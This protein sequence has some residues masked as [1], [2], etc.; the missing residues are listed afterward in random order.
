MFVMREWFRRLFV[1][2]IFEDEEKTRTAQI[3]NTFGWIAFAVVFIITLSR[4]VTGEWL[5]PSSRVFFPAILL[6]LFAIQV[7]IRY[8]FVRAAGYSLVIFMWGALTYQASQSDGVRDVA[9]L[10]YPVIILLAALL[11]GWREGLATGVF[12]LAVLWFFAWQESTGTRQYTIDP[13]LSYARDL[14]AVFIITSVLVYILI[15]R[16]NRSLT[17]AQLELRERLRVENK[18]QLQANYL[19]ALHETAFGLLNRLELNPLLESILDRAS[20]LL[21][22][23]HVGINLVLPDDSALRQELGRGAFAP[24]NGDLTHKGE[25][26]TGKVW[27][28]G[29][30]I[31]TQNYNEYEFGTATAREKGFQAVLGVPLKSGQKVV[32]ALIVGHTDP[33]SQFTPEQVVL[34][35]RLAALAS[36]AFD[37]AR[38][39]EDAHTE[40]MERKLVERDLRA[41]EERFRKVFNNKNVAVS[42]V[43][44]EEGIF[45]E[46]ND[47]FWRLSG[48]SPEKALGHS[49]VELHMWE[50][51]GQREKFVQELLKTGSLQDVEVL[52][53]DGENGS[54]VS[55]AYYELI[56]I[57]EQQCIL[58][59]FYDVSG[60]R[61][62]ERALKESE[63]RFRKV[64]YASPIAICITTLEEGRLLDA[65]KAYWDLTGYDPV[66]SINLTVAEL[67]MWDA[68]DLRNAFVEEIKEKR[69]VL[70]P[71]YEFFE[72]GSDKKHH[73]IA[74]YELID[75]NGQ[76]CILSMFYDITEQRSAEDALKSAEARTRAILNAIPDMIFEVSRSGVILDFMA[77]AGYSPVMEPSKFLG[78]NIQELFPAVIAEQ[79]FFA[80]ERS[81]ASGQ[82]HAF[83]YGL[84][85]GEDVQFF[86]A[87][88]SAV[89]VESAIMM[90]RDISQRR[91][92]ETE[93]EK[94][95][96]EL[97]EK[98]SE[99]ERFTYTVS[100]D[101]KSPLITIKGFLGFL[102]QD[103]SS[104]NMTRLRGDLQR[105]GDA[106]DKMQALLNELLELSRIG[107]LVNPPQLVPFNRVIEEA[108]GLVQGR[109]HAK[110]IEV[111]VQKNLPAVYGD[112]QRL[113]EVMQNLIDNSA[114]FI[115]SQQQPIIEIGQDGVEGEKPIFFVRDNGMGIEPVH[116]DRIFGL[117]NKLDAKSEGTGV[118]LALVKRIIEV[119]TGRI[120]VKSELGK[121]ATFYFTLPTGPA[122]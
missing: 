2:S 42:I 71:N 28:Q 39:Y 12:S 62:T 74:L 9:I 72:V 101:L 84:P 70:N 52:F 54:K 25:A 69:S 100:H 87:R 29:T 11:L 44:L 60:Q 68:P 48:L 85:P 32:G 4:I 117:F 96:Q 7:L 78:R 27:E 59:M 121:G 36:L 88:V 97:E 107:R 8:G 92:V 95:I 21:G 104:G 119:H 46:A 94:L 57:R 105:I 1:A 31:L 120:W 118:G 63:E 20:H 86:E 82:L 13:P 47:A 34:L 109:L 58:C 56:E 122:S 14:S 16:L 106:T 77:S 113:V 6:I 115:G 45:L 55:L 19:T 30:T 22:T 81:L 51:P 112:Q 111:K 50:Q 75:L 64:F 38:L 99:L 80:L 43:T 98:N 49:S 83:E 10:A 110:N 53:S 37:N 15:Q 41:S 26:L 61:Q 65:N 67:D 33:Q 17:G 90:V 5:S 73:A 3:L 18:L 103:A 93:R 89:T 114:K 76:A 79:T 24:W 108:Q 66:T 40:I 23:P 102:E 116:H 91:W 35:E